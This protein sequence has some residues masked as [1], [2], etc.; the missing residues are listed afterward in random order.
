MKLSVIVPCYN[1]EGNIPLFHKACVEALSEVLQDTELIYI[2]DGSK[3]GT[4]A[5]LSKLVD[6]SPCAVRVINFSRN[7]GK[8]AALLAGLRAGTGEY[9]VIIDADMQQR[10]EYIMEMYKILEE[11]PEYDVVAAYQDKRKES[12]VL[13]WCK[14]LF[15]KVINSLTDVEFVQSA[16]DFRMFRRVVVDAML[17]LTERCRFTKGIFAWVGFNTYYMPYKVE[18]RATG[19]S[20]WNFFKLLK[21][22]MDGIMAF[23]VKPL[24]IVS[25]LGIIV[26]M[27]SIVCTVYVVIKTLIFGDPV[28]GFP[29][30]VCL[31]MMLSGIQLLSIGILGQYLAKNYTETKARPS[32]V[33][34]EVLGG[35]EKHEG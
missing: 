30:L 17:S 1:E 18:A 16:S 33:I 4:L 25:V 12:K 26:F 3:D 28:A 23:S 22:A 2:N 31:I 24:L 9:T 19:K 11:K 20:N 14:N 10:P 34:K 6:T 7:F 5:E 35:D 15:Y 32:Y 21:Y 27:L 13:S 8:E 29:T